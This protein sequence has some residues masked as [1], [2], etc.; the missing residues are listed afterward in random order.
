MTDQ[1]LTYL[2]DKG[3]PVLVVLLLIIYWGYKLLLRKEDVIDILAG[4]VDGVKSQ[5]AD[6]RE[7]QASLVTL[8]EG[9]IYGKH[10]LHG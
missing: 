5:M 9:L 6:N 10:N 3:G 7:T 8:L 2:M 1:I 4:S